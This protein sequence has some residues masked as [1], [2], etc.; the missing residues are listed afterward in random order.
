MIPL[1]GEKRLP[2]ELANREPTKRLVL[3]RPAPKR[4]VSKIEWPSVRWLKRDVPK[5]PESAGSPKREF[6]PACAMGDKRE[7]ERAKIGLLEMRPRAAADDPARGAMEER[8]P[9]P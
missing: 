9:L 4:L 7:P 3:E 1:R 6:R 2:N 8:A 5:R